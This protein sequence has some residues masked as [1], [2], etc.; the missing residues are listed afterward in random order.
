MNGDGGCNIAIHKQKIVTKNKFFEIKIS[1]DEEQWNVYAPSSIEK[2]ADHSVMFISGRFMKNWKQLLKVRYCVVFW[3]KEYPVF[4]ELNRRHLILPCDNPRLEYARFFQAHHI[5]NLPVHEPANNL[6]ESCI[7]EKACLGKHITV[8]PGAYIGPEVLIGDNVYI[9][10]GVCLLGKV[11]VGNHVVIRENSVIGADGLSMEREADG[12]MI[13]IP[14]FGGVCIQDEVQIGANV[15]VARGSIDDTLIGK[16]TIIDNHC[17]ISHNVKIGENV[18]IVGESILFGSS[19]VGNNS[20]IS[21]NVAV[22][23]GKKIGK[24]TLIGM[25]SVVVKDVSDDSIMK[26]NPAVCIK[27]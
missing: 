17:F 27:K 12:R 19:E 15:T 8:M 6:S 7:S 2:P 1:N 23:D 4:T 22:R 20:F 18:A 11:T 3:P 14:Q 9:G 13:S 21:G 24:N 16:G 25:G 10:H 26:G 5:K